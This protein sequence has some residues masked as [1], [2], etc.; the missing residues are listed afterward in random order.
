MNRIHYKKVSSAI[1]T[2]LMYQKVLR[3]RYTW[4]LNSKCFFL[5]RAWM[6]PNYNSDIIHWVFN[7]NVKFERIHGDLLET[8]M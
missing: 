8:E 6:E 5:Q 7:T 3:G 4:S 2:E 1:S